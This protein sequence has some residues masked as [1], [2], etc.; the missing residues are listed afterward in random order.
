VDKQLLIVLVNAADSKQVRPLPGKVVVPTHANA[1]P[2]QL[3][4]DRL[5]RDDPRP[6]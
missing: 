5:L 4:A 3:A 2:V 6:R 1:S